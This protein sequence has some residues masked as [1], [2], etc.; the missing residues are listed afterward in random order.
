MRERAFASGQDDGVDLSIL[1]IT[2]NRA[3]L[4]ATTFSAVRDRMD[5]ASL[6]VEFIVSDDASDEPHLSGVLSL[7]FDRHLIAEKNRGLGHNCN[8]AIAAS[9]G[10]Y[11]LQI[12]DDCEFVG[13][14][15]RLLTAM[16]ILEADPQVGCVQLDLL[17]P[18]LAHEKRRLPNGTVYRVFDNDG[19]RRRTGSPRPYSDR[20]HV[21]RRRFH[22]DVGPYDER[23]AAGDTELSYQ[24][25]V[26][27]QRR[28]RVAAIEA[29]AGFRHIGELRS[30]NLN[31][32]RSQR[33]ARLYALS[34]VGPVLQRLR[35]AAR[36]VRDTALDL[37]LWR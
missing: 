32:V 17:T 1:F 19:L 10:R 6:R 29:P 15:D 13:A 33:L 16:R 4:L 20:P 34:F 14:P 27:C 36:L 35:P 30:V 11:L 2:Y 12:Q 25:R 9:H 26:A 31:Y 21:K 37:G 24:R 5:F 8:K 18:G 28:W 22:E 23:M 7:P 3:D